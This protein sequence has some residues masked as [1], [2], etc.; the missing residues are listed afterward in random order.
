MMIY[1]ETEK[2]MADYMRK[3]CFSFMLCAI[4]ISA[5]ACCANSGETS[6]PKRIS[7]SSAEEAFHLESEGKIK[8]ESRCV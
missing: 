4:L 6:E 7:V 8:I 2:K 5:L 1:D 3:K